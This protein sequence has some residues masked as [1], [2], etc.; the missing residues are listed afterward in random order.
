MTTVPLLVLD[1]TVYE[2]TSKRQNMDERST[3]FAVHVSPSIFNKNKCISPLNPS[4]IQL[5]SGMIF[6]PMPKE[7]GEPPF[8]QFF[9]GLVPTK[10]T[11]TL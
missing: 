5:L 9:L 2:G 8:C 6:L 10:K 7:K 1:D 11:I 3:H 4:P